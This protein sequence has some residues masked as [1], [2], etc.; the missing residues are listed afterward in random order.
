MSVF[1]PSEG[2]DPTVIWAAA[3]DHLK[4]YTVGTTLTMK[5]TL[6]DGEEEDEDEVTGRLYY[7]TRV[8]GGDLWP[9]LK[10][11]PKD[12]M[13]VLI[14]TRIAK[15]TIVASPQQRARSE[16][17]LASAEEAC[18]RASGVSDEAIAEHK[19]K[20]QTASAQEQQRRRRRS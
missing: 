17:R 5:T 9:H 15:L 8:P 3:L 19:R 1:F 4:V 6:H 20:D 10:T 7:F 2:N 13:A 12:W 18:W 11:G 14:D 16:P